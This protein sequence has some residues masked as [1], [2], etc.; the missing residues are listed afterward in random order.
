MPRVPESVHIKIERANHHIDD[1]KSKISVFLESNPYTISGYIDDTNRPTYR[2]SN[3]QPIPPSLLV[4]TGDAVQ[5]LRSALDYLACALWLRDHPGIAIRSTNGFALWKLE[6]IN[7]SQCAPQIYPEHVINRAFTG[8][9][10]NPAVYFVERHFR[11]LPIK[12]L[13]LLAAHTV[14]RASNHSSG[15]GGLQVVVCDALGFR[16]LDEYEIERLT[17]RSERADAELGRLLGI[18]HTE[19]G[20]SA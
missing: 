16:E 11:K 15:V 12:D 8:D 3:V 7:N 1:L 19:R 10:S 6:V 2:V 18:A 5:N 13:L 14:L 9:V 17:E 4:I 20:E